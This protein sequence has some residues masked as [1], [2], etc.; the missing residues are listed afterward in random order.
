MTEV[1]NGQWQRIYPKQVGKFDCNP[2]NLVT[3]KLD[4]GSY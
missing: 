1:K 2:K 3:I 4:V